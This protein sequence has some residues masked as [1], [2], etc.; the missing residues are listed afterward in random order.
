VR[1]NVTTALW[2]ELA[3]VG[4]TDV[5]NLV[6]GATSVR[7]S[8]DAVRDI[9]QQVY[10]G[11]SDSEK[12][13]ATN[14]E[15]VQ[16]VSQAADAAATEHDATFGDTSRGKIE[17]ALWSAMHT[18][19]DKVP[20]VR[21]AAE[22]R[23]IVSCLITGMKETQVSRPSTKCLSPISPADV[24][25]GLRKEYDA[26]FYTATQRDAGVHSGHPF[27]VEAGLAYGGDIGAEGDIEVLRFANRVPLVYQPGACGTTQTVA[28]IGW[29]NYK[30]KQSG[31]SGIPDGPV[32]LMIHVGSTNVP[33]TSESKDALASVPDIEYEVE[34]AVREVARD[35]KK[36]LKKQKSRQ[37]RQRKQNVIAD[38]LP[39]MAEKLADTTGVET[40]AHQGTLAQVMNNMHVK[41]ER[42]GDTMTVTMTN[43]TGGQK[44]FTVCNTVDE[45][46]TSDDEDVEIAAQDDETWRVE[47]R[48][49][50]RKNGTAS[51]VY[52]VGSDATHEFSFED[53]SDEKLT[54]AV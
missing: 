50:V 32:V 53:L 31:G 52:T 35:M 2:D 5:H 40:P 51:F 13:R 25:A 46:P 26:D 44:T 7:K 37:K 16:L 36:H 9:A 28:S 14:Q 41:Q 6:F 34:Q 21:V 49:P 11:L 47:W 30:L 43:H 20:L 18:V 33:F 39:T 23:D 38:I 24:E 27:I 8:D 54:V 22:D 17:G 29:R 1:S 19:D 48:G 3:T 45:E 15:I 4:E 10:E 42:T 12:Y